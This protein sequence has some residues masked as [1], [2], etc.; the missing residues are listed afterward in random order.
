MHLD[1][2]V[3][4]PLRDLLRQPCQR[5]AHQLLEPLSLHSGSYDTEALAVGAT[6]SARA[7]GRELRG[8]WRTE[9]LGAEA[10]HTFELWVAVQ[11]YGAAQQG[12]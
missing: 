7:G 1:V 4:H 10:R 2:D 12:Q 11:Q 3:A 6:T 9:P 8:A 5:S